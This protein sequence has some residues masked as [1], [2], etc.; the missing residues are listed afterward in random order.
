MLFLQ[1]FQIATFSKARNIEK[2]ECIVENEK[3]TG[4]LYDLSGLHKVACNDPH[5]LPLMAQLF[6]DTI[7]GILNTMTIAAETANWK[8]VGDMAHKLK[9]TIDSMKIS[10]LSEIIREAERDG[11]LQQNTDEL[12]GKVDYIVSV[13]QQCIARLKTEFSL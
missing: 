3:I 6:I 11:K 7:P 8:N 9:A 2:M 5:F 13:L 10:L 4:K 1:F 12:P